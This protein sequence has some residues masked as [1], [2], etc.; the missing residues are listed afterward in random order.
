M[1]RVKNAG[2]GAR[3]RLLQGAGRG[4]RIGGFGG[5]GVD[6]LAREAGLTSGAFY[7]HFGSKADAFRL[8]V[9]RG[10]AFL[11]DGVALFQDRCGPGWRDP[12]VDFYFGERMRLGIE[13]A[14]ALP[15]SRPMSLAPMRRRGRPISR[16]WTDLSRRSRPALAIRPI[17]NAP[18][19]FSRCYPAGRA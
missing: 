11:R 5:I 9:G 15:S 13:E 8:A 7:A 19:L 10:I 16:N 4:F 1:G 12:F 6:A 14:C 3:E 17:A 18:G 2:D